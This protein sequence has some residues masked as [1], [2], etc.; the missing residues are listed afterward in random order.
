MHDKKILLIDTIHPVFKL[1]LEEA[2]FICTEGYDM[3]DT[4]I[5]QNIAS[6]TGIVI[7]SRIPINKQLLEHAVNLKFIARAGAG[8]ENIDVDYARQHSILCINAPEGNRN[9][10]GEHALMMILALFNNLRQ[11]D[12]A[13]REGKW[14]R[15]EN[16]G[17]ELQGKTIGIIGFGNMGSA[18]AEKLK[19]FDVNLL[20]YDKYIKLDT[21]Y[22]NELKQVTMDVIFEQADIISLHVPLTE[23]TTYLVDDSFLKS[24]RKN[25]FIIN[26]A[27]GKCVKTD[28]LVKHLK[29]GKVRGACL[30]VLE[31]E[32]GS[33][34]KMDAEKI[35]EAFQYLA[36]ASNVI[37]TPHIAGWTHESQLKIAETLVW[38]IKNLNLLEGN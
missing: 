15:E 25:I 14:L 26:T 6:F 4:F 23:E 12:A 29:T 9:A 11:A 16:R 24:F 13:V 35:P 32:T 10:V 7:R 1:R 21:K 34:E 36:Q 38:K 2:G 27:R 8:M 18:F 31:Y 5:K 28:D 22:Y 17:I 30:D 20:I 33:F 3:S 37:M 19:G